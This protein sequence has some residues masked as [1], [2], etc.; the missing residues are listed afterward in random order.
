MGVERVGNVPE[1]ILMDTERALEGGGGSRIDMTGCYTVMESVSSN[2]KI[3]FTREKR[4]M[5]DE[6]FRATWSDLRNGTGH[7]DPGVKVESYIHACIERQQKR[8][9][10]SPCATHV[11]HHRALSFRAIQLMPLPLNSTTGDS[12]LLNTPLSNE[13][14][15]IKKYSPSWTIVLFSAVSRHVCCI[16]LRFSHTCTPCRRRRRRE[17][18]RRRRRKAVS[19][20]RGRQ[21]RVCSRT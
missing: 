13:K 12:R 2:S 5:G 21:S 20:R 10:N 9:H 6:K 19:I 18:C 4:M 17:I 1:R 15:I 3:D 11:T 14:D 8:A 16:F 7:C